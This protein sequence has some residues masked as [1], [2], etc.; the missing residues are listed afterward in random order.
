MEFIAVFVFTLLVTGLLAV[1]LYYTRNTRYR[2]TRR[3]ILKLLRGVEARTTERAAWE[4]FIGYPL[5]YD[6]EL[7]RIRQCCVEI[8]EGSDELPPASPGLN[9]YL[10]DRAGRERIAKLADE[11][12]RLIEKEPVYREF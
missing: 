4:M 6:P 3:Q 2:P 9:G 12:A 10:Y 5:Y 11:L 7:D 8:E 1:V